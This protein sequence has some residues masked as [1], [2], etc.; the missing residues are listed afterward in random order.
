[1]SSDRSGETDGEDVGAAQSEAQPAACAFHL[2]FGL[3]IPV[4]EDGRGCQRCDNAPTDADN[5][6]EDDDDEL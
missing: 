1:M 3:T 6:G 5:Y 4:G 2:L